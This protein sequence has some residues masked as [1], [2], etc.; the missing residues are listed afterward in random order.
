MRVSLSA[1]HIVKRYGGVVALA[2]GNI[3]INSGEVVALLGANGCG[4]STLGKIITGVAS[5][6]E[7]MLTVNGQPTRFNSPK[8]ARRLGIT[9]VYQEL[10]LV[11]DMTVSENIWLSQEPLIGRT[12]VNRKDMHIKTADLLAL[13]EGTY[14]SLSPHVLVKDLPPDERQI[15]EILKALSQRPNLLILDEATASLDSQQ[16]KRLFELVAGWKAQGMAIAFVSHRMDEIFQV[17]DKATVLRGGYT[18]G[19]RE[20]ANTNRAELIEMMI[21]DAS[22]TQ[23]VSQKPPRKTFPIRLSVDNLS[24]NRLK[25]ISFQ[26][27]EGELIGL[28]GLQG[29]GQSDLLLTLFGAIPHTG[30]ITL[31]DQKVRFSHPK[32]AMEKQI[33]FVPG[34]RGSE[35]LLLSRSILENIQLP[36]WGKYGFPLRIGQARRDA[37]KNGEDLRL[38]MSSLDARV[39]SLSGGNAQKVVIGKWLAQNPTVLLLNDPT[40]GVDVGAKAEFYTLLT[41][42][43]EQGTSILFYSSDDDE[44]LGLCSRV[45]VL[46]DGKI[47]AD[48]TDERLTHADLVDASMG[49]HSVQTQGDN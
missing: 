15:V 43:V 41:K 40:K 19:D 4:K 45:L 33:A 44:L 26:V 14:Q 48:L 27:A 3:T 9:A 7:G 23:V 32:Q 6:D 12:F 11:Q 42:L 30:T 22:V 46:H 31:N 8:A 24:T 1:Q 28:G 34:D 5:P 18:I 39:D 17:A 20:I 10:S 37:I 25:N 21:K 29:Q 36:S 35:G 13:F 47:T 38:V 49:S 16:V 2:D